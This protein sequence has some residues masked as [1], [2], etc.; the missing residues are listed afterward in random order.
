VAEPGNHGRLTLFIVIFFAVWA[1]RATVLFFI[2]EK[3]H[4]E[5][6]LFAYSNLIKFLLWVVPAALYIR[7]VDKRPV[8]RYLRLTTRPNGRALIYSILIAALYFAATI[9]FETLVSGRNLKSLTAATPVEWLRVLLVVSISPV[10]EEILFRG[11]V[12]SKLNEITGFWKANLVTAALFVFIHWPHW[13]WRNGFHRS[14]IQ[15]SLG[16]FVLA[17]LLGYLVRL[18]GSLWPSIATH[19]LN[20]FLSHFLGT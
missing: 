3:I 13:L 20:N 17:L 8:M 16:I 14:M 6:A 2:D 9:L 11:F 4:S 18:T 15:V 7:Y 1:V 10:S 12:L 19:I 5:Y